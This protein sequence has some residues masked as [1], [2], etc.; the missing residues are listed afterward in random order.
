MDFQFIVARCKFSVFKII[1]NI[2]RFH[3]RNAHTIRTEIEALKN[4]FNN[5]FKQV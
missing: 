3:F 1:D 2:K 4:D 5:R